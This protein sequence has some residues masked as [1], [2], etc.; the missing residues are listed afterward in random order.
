M[1]ERWH[2]FLKTA[3][4][5][6]LNHK[7][8]IEEL[9]II[10]FRVESGT[11]ERYERLHHIHDTSAIA[12]RTQAAR[13]FPRTRPGTNSLPYMVRGAGRCSEGSYDVIGS[14]YRSPRSHL[15]ATQRRWRSCPPESV[16]SRLVPKISPKCVLSLKGEAKAA[17]TTLLAT[18]ADSKIIITSL[19]RSFGRP[20]AIIK[21]PVNDIRTLP[22]RLLHR[23][24][25]LSSDQIPNV[26]SIMRSL[27]E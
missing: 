1:V 20:E 17:V 11:T 21:Q 13:H 27:D 10:L 4:R 12:Q 3:L 7:S 22:G 25:K 18:I 26:V 23:R 9:P 19:E 8:W 16:E 2:R 6:R 15:Y 5:A 24:F 14:Q